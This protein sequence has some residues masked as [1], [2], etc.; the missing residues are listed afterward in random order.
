MNEKQDNA[1]TFA[2]RCGIAIIALVLCSA[3][4][5]MLSLVSG[6]VRAYEL[7]PGHEFTAHTVILYLSALTT[8]FYTILS[9]WW[10]Q[11]GLVVGKPLPLLHMRPIAFG[12]LVLV[13]FLIAQLSPQEL[14]GWR[15]DTPAEAA[16]FKAMKLASLWLA[17]AKVFVSAFIWVWWCT[18]VPPTKRRVVA[19]ACAWL[20]FTSLTGILYI[21]APRQFITFV[22]ARYASY[23]PFKFNFPGSDWA[24]VWHCESWMYK[25]NIDVGE[26][27][28]GIIL[29]SGAAILAAILAV[30]LNLVI[31]YQQ[32]EHSKGW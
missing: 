3:M 18:R 4:N 30:A 26:F 23:R 11:R 28:F 9:L 27:F 16:Q 8:F 32:S 24:L 12:V 31:M 19:A 5:D 17:V 10:I 25:T 13:A 2:R 7:I 1:I 6:I 20:G 22:E 29:L 14:S 21:T 15:N